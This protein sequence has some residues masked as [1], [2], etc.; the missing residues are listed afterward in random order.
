MT[1]TPESVMS[2]FDRREIITL[3]R[4][5]R[6]LGPLLRDLLNSYIHELSEI[7]P[8]ERGPDGRFEYER[9]SVYW[10]EP[11]GR[12]AF[13]INRGDNVAGFALATRGSPATD[14]PDDY[15]V[16]E[17]FVLPA[18]RRWGVGRHAA[19]ALWN[20]MPG[21]WVVRVSEANRPGLRFWTEVIAAYTS[22]T[23]GDGARPDHP[24]GWRVFTFD[25]RTR[26]RNR[27]AR[28]GP[29]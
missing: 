23:F 10:D 20:E 14:D 18:Y 1:H 27:S 7:F 11:E 5:T 3:Q 8:V 4:A 15:D 17:F 12:H 13:V 21:Q 28:S 16:A 9:L 26:T 2:D 6:D 19:I 29:S 22:G 24:P 25:S